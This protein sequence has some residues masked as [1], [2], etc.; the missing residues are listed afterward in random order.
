MYQ[1]N[2]G[3]TSRKTLLVSASEGPNTNNTKEKQMEKVISITTDNVISVQEVD[4]VD[5]ELL[6]TS[7]NGMVELVSIDRNVDMWLNE[8][9]KL[10]NLPN[11]IIATILWN[12]L[13]SNNPDIIKGDIVITG[14]S[15]DM[16]NSTGLSDN[17]IKDILLAIEDGIMTAIQN[18]NG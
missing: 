7:V 6:S 18:A 10:L 1:I 11:N 8:E 2:T 12:K 17:S 9:G 14:G 13:F 16:G 4:E 15:D 3:N 5:Y